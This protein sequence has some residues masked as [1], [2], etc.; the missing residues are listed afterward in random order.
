MSNFNYLSDIED[1]REM[2][3]FLLSRDNKKVVVYYHELDPITSIRYD[4]FHFYLKY[5]KDKFARITQTKFIGDPLKAQDALY[6]LSNLISEMIGNPIAYYD[7]CFRESGISHVNPTFE[8]CLDKNNINNYI[9]SI[10]NN[11]LFDDGSECL[12]VK[13]FNTNKEIKNNKSL[14]L[15]LNK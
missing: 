13:I 4:G 12:N 7:M 14:K 3:E 2:V 5:S 1:C 15:S 9:F 10:E 6:E 8:W 11:R